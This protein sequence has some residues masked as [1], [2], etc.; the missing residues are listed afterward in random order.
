MLCNSTCVAPCSMSPFCKGASNRPSHSASSARRSKDQLHF[1]SAHAG[2]EA[3]APLTTTG[4]V[5]LCASCAKVVG[6]SLGTLFQSKLGTP[7]NRG[8]CDERAGADP[9]DDGAQG[10]IARACETILSVCH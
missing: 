4:V 2:H 10:A 8:P 7:R 5:A 6:R 9:S 1:L 3:A